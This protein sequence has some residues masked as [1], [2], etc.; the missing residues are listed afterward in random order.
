V[1]DQS[2]TSLAEEGLRMGAGWQREG[3]A[4]RSPEEAGREDLGLHRLPAGVEG[5]DKDQV[6]PQ[7]T[8]VRPWGHWDAR[9][10]QSARLKAKQSPARQEGCNTD[11]NAT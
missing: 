9:P 4:V 5:G 8:W 3:E 10:A 11:Q 2:R 7:A 1:C 6:K